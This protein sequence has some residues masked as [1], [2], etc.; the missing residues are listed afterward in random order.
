MTDTTKKN[1]IECKCGCCESE[2]KCPCCNCDE[3]GYGSPAPIECPHGLIL[4]STEW[5]SKCVPKELNSPAP[6]E[7]ESKTEEISIKPAKGTCCPEMDVTVCRGCGHDHGREYVIQARLDAQ[8]EILEKIED[9]VDERVK[10]YHKTCLTDDFDN[11]KFWG[12]K[13]MQGFLSELKS[14]LEEVKI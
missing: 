2:H 12:Y 1:T 8:R 10:F 5:C 4:G 7:S 6:K 13:D 11:G 3:N 9:E 14:Q